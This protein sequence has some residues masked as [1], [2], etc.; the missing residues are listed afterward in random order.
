MEI[1]I[2]RL[3]AEAL[4][5]NLDDLAEILQASVAAGAS[6]NFVLPYSL[7]DSRTFWRERVLPSVKRG[8]RTLLVARLGDKVAGT[9]QLDLEMP[10]NQA[11]RCEV[12][13]LLV[14]PDFRNRGIAKRLMVALES[15]ARRLGKALVTLDTRTG[16]NAEPLYRGLGYLTAGVIPGFAR[17]PEEE[18][19]DATTYMYKS[20]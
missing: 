12:S 3:D 1:E 5:A 10:P 18:R 19:Y 16:D 7:D 11:H 4:V 14:H 8:T 2:K 13:K 17:A 20:L 15:E 6:V 9:V